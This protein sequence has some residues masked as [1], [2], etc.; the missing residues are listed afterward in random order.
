MLIVTDPDGDYIQ[1]K[2]KFI[3]FESTKFED[4]FPEDWQNTD[5]LED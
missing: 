1:D 5:E 3:G 4:E 2:Y